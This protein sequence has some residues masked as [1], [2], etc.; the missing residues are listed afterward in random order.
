MSL[1]DFVWVFCGN[2]SRFP[3]A[4]FTVRENAEA[5]IKS[6]KL[7]GVLTCYP[8]NISVYEW[9]IEEEYFVPKKAHESTPQFMQNFS[10]ASQEHYHY[11]EGQLD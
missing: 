3:S 6:N 8:L 5:W 9:A 4:I 11:L 10:S 1:R 7:T 2:S